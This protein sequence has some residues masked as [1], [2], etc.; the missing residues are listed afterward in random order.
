[1]VCSIESSAAIEQALIHDERIVFYRIDKARDLEQALEV[2][3][4]DLVFSDLQLPEF[5]AAELL[6][7]LDKNG[8]DVPIVVIKGTG[9]DEIAMRCLEMGIC[10][11]IRCTPAYLQSLPRVVDD[12]LRRAEKEHERRLVEQAL[13]QSEARLTDVLNH[14][15]DLIQCVELDGALSYTNRSWR[16]VMGYTEQEVKSLNLLDLL[17]PDSM[18]CCQDRFQRLMKGESLKCVDF[19][20]VTKSGENVFLEG[21]CGSI[22]KEG[23]VIS[24]R[25]IFRNVTDIVK[26]REALKVTEA[27]YQTLYDNSPDIFTTLSASGEILS[28]NRNGAAMLG[29]ERTELIG[30]SATKVIHPEDQ[31]EVFRCVEKLFRD[32]DEKIDIEY[33]KIR[34]DGSTFWVHQRASLEP[35]VSVPRLLV[36]CRDI[37]DKRNLE[38]KLAYQASHDALTSLLNRRAFEQRLQHVLTREPDPTDQHILCFLDLDQFKIINDTCGHIA[39]DELLRQVA[40]LLNGLVRSRDTL[41]RIG[42]DEFAVLMEHATLDS[43]IKF[44]EKIRSTIEA[45]VFHWRTERF[46]IGVSIGVVPIQMGRTFTD[47]LNRADMACYTAKKEGRNRVHAN[48][49]EN[50]CIVN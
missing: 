23:G 35:G 22:V 4:W 28:I 12:L 24:T 26:A 36:V 1:M 29:Y 49:T 44:A 18:V 46:S 48:D 7:L 14:T 16:E 20:F 2:S 19:K 50:I 30:E 25:G 5:D 31:R 15:S 39:G 21:D 27:Q 17:H 41:A 11:F 45:F 37:T 8:M 6:S 34:K 13:L 42:G 10:Q 9:A 43:A 38:D 47:T 3:D 33:R 40:A 32:P